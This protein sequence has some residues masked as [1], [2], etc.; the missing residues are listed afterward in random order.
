MLKPKHK[1]YHQ[2]QGQLHITKKQCCDL[3]VWTTKDMQVIRIVVDESWKCNITKL[4]Q[5]YFDVFIPSL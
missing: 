3:I 2:I 4:I 1:Y 5:F